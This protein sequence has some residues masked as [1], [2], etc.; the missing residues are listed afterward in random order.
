MARDENP[1]CAPEQQYKS[2]SK[3][4]STPGSLKGENRIWHSPDGLRW[5]LADGVPSGLR[6]ADTQPSW[7]WDHRIGRY[8]GY[9]REW[10]H[11]AGNKRVRMIGYNE[12]DDMLHWD[13]FQLALKPDEQDG[14]TA[15][16][17]RVIGGAQAVDGGDTTEDVSPSRHPWTSTLRGY[18]NIKKLKATILR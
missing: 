5:K 15:P 4:Y 17:V 9:S 7:L 1:N 14:T 13:S 10:V 18:S 11:L 12:S 6:K 8:L 3:F 16:V 2:W